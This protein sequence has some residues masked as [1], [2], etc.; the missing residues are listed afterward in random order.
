[1]GI[2]SDYF[3]PKTLIHIWNFSGTSFLASVSN[4]TASSS[5]SQISY[6]LAILFTSISFSFF[7]FFSFCFSF[8]SHF[9]PASS[10]A[11]SS[12][13]FCH[14]D[15]L[16]FSLHCL[17]HSSGHL[18]ILTFPVLQ[19]ISRLWQA[20]HSIPKITLYFCPSITSISVLFLCLW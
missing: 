11:S 17:P 14:P 19:S 1:M 20:S 8:L 6:S 16:C 9:L 15:F 3:L 18:V 4:F 5:S 7:C 2:L 13:C 10:F 12:F